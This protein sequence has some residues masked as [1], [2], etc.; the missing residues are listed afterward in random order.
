[1]A[2]G[3]RLPGAVGALLGLAAMLSLSE[4]AW[5]DV[6]CRSYRIANGTHSIY[7]KD[8]WVC[9]ANDMC[10]PGPELRAEM[11]RQANAARNKMIEAI[12][13]SIAA[14]DAEKVRLKSWGEAMQK[15]FAAMARNAQIVG[16][17]RSTLPQRPCAGQQSASVC[18]N[19]ASGAGM[20]TYYPR[21][22][23]GGPQRIS[24]SCSDITGLGG[25][26][27]HCKD[28]GAFSALAQHQRGSNPAAAAS[29]LKAAQ[30]S[31]RLAGDMA[32]ANEIARQLAALAQST[33]ASQPSSTDQVA[34]ASPQVSGGSRQIEFTPS[35][36]DP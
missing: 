27:V 33:G 21:R 20:T 12:N 29:F 32:M 3:R 23:A 11:A 10:A 35:E 7:C 18:S 17:R 30:N 25:R 5:S 4:P 28:A 2:H 22:S 8:R 36:M 14:I 9:V 19:V 34:S 1:M 31:Y 13:H 6:F 15:R 26:T 16:R 24:A